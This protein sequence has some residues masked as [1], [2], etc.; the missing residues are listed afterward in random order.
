MMVYQYRR[1]IAKTILAAGGEG[2]GGERATWAGILKVVRE[3]PAMVMVV[4]I[5]LFMCKYHMILAKAK[6]NENFAICRDRTA[7]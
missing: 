7:C 6:A 4:C 3:S 1:T 2:E 5:R